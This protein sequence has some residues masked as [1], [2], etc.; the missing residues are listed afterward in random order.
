[1]SS[2]L[3]AGS[4][5][6]AALFQFGVAAAQT[7][8]ERL[9]Q[10]RDPRQEKRRE[11]I[12]ALR[13]FPGD[14]RVLD[15]LLRELQDKSSDSRS[16]AAAALG[17]LATEPSRTVPALIDAL[18]DPWPL[19]RA[20]A[21]GAL[22]S[23]GAAASPALP[24]LG[25]LLDD[26][27]ETVRRHV[28]LALAG[29]AAGS[30]EAQRMIETRTRDSAPYVRNT[31]VTA[32]GRLGPQSTRYLP[33]FVSA[34]DDGSEQVRNAAI[35]GIL[36][37]GS[38]AAS[39]L[40]ALVAAS[41]TASLSTAFNLK[42]ALQVLVRTN[43]EET[44]SLLVAA[45]KDSGNPLPGR[46]FAAETLG[47]MGPKAASALPDLEKASAEGP[48]KLRS[49]AE[50]AILLL[51]RDRLESSPEGLARAIRLLADPSPFRRNL[52]ETALVHAGPKAVPL[53]IE[54]IR[55]E[56][57]D[58]ARIA[59][60]EALSRLSASGSALTLLCDL[61]AGGGSI[62][63]RTAALSALGRMIVPR[64]QVARIV[65]TLAKAMEDPNLRLP[66][67]EAMGSL[68]E[69]G[70]GGV[71]AIVQALTQALDSNPRGDAVIRQCLSALARIGPPAQLALPLVLPLLR[72][73]R[74]G[75]AAMGHDLSL[76]DDAD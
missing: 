22:A 67:I 59:A 38:A 4:L 28:V 71:P 30:P 7:V 68:D 29:F 26:P 64:S 6:I 75:G 41:R 51:T 2:S 65:G 34:L 49:A 73:P 35:D 57:G 61:A 58:T 1:M 42:R 15:A 10:L 63:L 27:N 17:Q 20:S 21:A 25:A 12:M 3:A 5:L 33:L 16:I 40:P 48:E 32:L 9:Q 18:D 19:M 31:A 70:A 72:D 66:A 11:A 45:L 39:A 69:Q 37:L 46:V 54:S 52:G 23:F 8:E 50:D 56:S 60:I 62:G 43:S 24:K 74:L 55:Q 13:T 44:I 47:E 36:Q 53:L 14:S 76:W